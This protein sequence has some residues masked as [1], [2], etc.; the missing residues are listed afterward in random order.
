VA[1]AVLRGRRAPGF[2]LSS[3]P[4]PFTAPS[5]LDVDEDLTSGLGAEELGDVAGAGD[6]LTVD[7]GDEVAGLDIDA[8]ACEGGGELRVVGI[9]LEDAFDLP[10]AV[11]GRGGQ[12]RAQGRDS[13]LVFPLAEV[14]APHKHVEGR[15]L[16]D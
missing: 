6:G 5:G 14:A 3:A 12:E 1:L 16:T 9:A 8:G 7:G 15:E 10:P 2:A 4:S 13:D 11:G